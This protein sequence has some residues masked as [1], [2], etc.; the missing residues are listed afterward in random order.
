MDPLSVIGSVAGIIQLSQAVSSGLANYIMTA[1]D[2]TGEVQELLSELKALQPV[3]QQL[4]SEV[5]VS[6]PPPADAT[7]DNKK[8][9]ADK[10]K[11]EE[12]NVTV[13]SG[14]PAALS[15][16]VLH[17]LEETRLVLEELFLKIRQTGLDDSTSPSEPDQGGKPRPSSRIGN[18]RQRASR[19]YKRLKYPWKKGDLEKL[20]QRLRDCKSSLSLALA[21][22]HR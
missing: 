8:N 17:T 19:A 12:I 21:V 6:L 10:G 22:D 2:A 5:V 18:L 4:Q 11:R 16:S 15:D 20:R 7:T 13:Q 14:A 1:K 9:G 3:L